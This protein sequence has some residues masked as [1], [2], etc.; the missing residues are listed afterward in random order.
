MLTCAAGYSVGALLS[1]SS[2]TEAA[3]MGTRVPLAL[4]KAQEGTFT[5]TWN[6]TV[7]KAE[8]GKWIIRRTSSDSGITSYVLDWSELGVAI[9]VR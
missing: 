3:A 4:F 8:F 6:F 1:I 7:P 9:I 5:G 2:F